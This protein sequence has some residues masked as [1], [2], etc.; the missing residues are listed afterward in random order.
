MCIL[1]MHCDSYLLAFGKR[2]GRKLFTSGL[3]LFSFLVSLARASS[4]VLRLFF[5]KWSL[6][7]C[8]GSVELSKIV[9]VER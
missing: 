4:E 3:F 7:P 1:C 6:R 5:R 9:E 2:M 8:F